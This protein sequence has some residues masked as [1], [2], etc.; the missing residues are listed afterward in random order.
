METTTTTT[1]TMN[2]D[3]ADP[4]NNVLL[5]DFGDEISIVEGEPNGQQY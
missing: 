1:T 3:S 5:I 2:V 4:L